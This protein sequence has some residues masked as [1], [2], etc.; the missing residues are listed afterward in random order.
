MLTVTTTT[1]TI[2]IIDHKLGYRVHQLLFSCNRQSALLK[3][4][5]NKKFY[6][7]AETIF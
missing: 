4:N 3:K 5:S 1:A 7:Q 6:Y 2:V